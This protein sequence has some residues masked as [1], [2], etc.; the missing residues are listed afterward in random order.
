MKK[1][2]SLILALAMICSLSLAG[3]ENTHINTFLI[4][5]FTRIGATD[6][7]T[8]QLS[9]EDPAFPE[10]VFQIE[11]KDGLL[12]A[13]LQ[14]N[15]TLRYTLQSDDKNAWISYPGGGF[16]ASVEDL[17]EIIAWIYTEAEKASVPG[18]T[19]AAPAPK[20]VAGS[21]EAEAAAVAV[22]PAAAAKKVPD[23]DS[24]IRGIKS[25]YGVYIG[26]LT[27]NV[28]TETK[29][30]E[31]TLTMKFDGGQPA[32]A[33]AALLEALVGNEDALTALL[34]ISDLS[35]MF[36]R[37]FTSLDAAPRGKRYGARTTFG[38]PEGQ[39]V[40]VETIKA[41][42]EA[43]KATYIED[44]KKQEEERL[45]QGTYF[46]YRDLSLEL[47]LDTNG[48][49]KTLTASVINTSRYAGPD[50]SPVSN[51]HTSTVKLAYE[52]SKL[53]VYG[54]N[55]RVAVITADTDDELCLY[56]YE[57]GTEKL[58]GKAKLELD[59]PYWTLTVRDAS[60]KVLFV[61]RTGTQLDF[62]KLSEQESLLQKIDLEM[63]KTQ[64]AP[65]AAAPAGGESGMPVYPAGDVV[66][67][68]ATA[69]P[70]DAA[71]DTVAAPTVDAWDS[72]V[73]DGI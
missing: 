16:Y 60:G 18:D 32:E 11:R 33:Q 51:T 54:D 50:G 41:A 68:A 56:T 65:P 20:A 8:Q 70:A 19:G 17:N 37:S 63:V 6:L 15:P 59:D 67:P 46:Q 58:L 5:L 31:Y 21:T 55:K 27:S 39:P 64:F 52:G 49:F 48:G 34:F 9:L 23:L 44:Q 30:G 36:A 2:L 26:I 43:N 61:L 14:I 1:A 22:E 3:A 42:W 69:A 57:S 45:A 40:T 10:P 29:D 28:T 13:S 66:A 25:L 38:V 4:N 53:V 12:N 7:D 73:G 72:A 62:K 71:G 47:V 24:L 35:E